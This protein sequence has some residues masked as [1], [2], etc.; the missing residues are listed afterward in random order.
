MTKVKRVNGLSEK[1]VIKMFEKQISAVSLDDGVSGVCYTNT[2]QTY[3]ANANNLREWS[4]QEFEK[5]IKLRNKRI[6][7]KKIITPSVENLFIELEHVVKNDFFKFIEI[8]QDLSFD[9]ETK[10]NVIIKKKVWKTFNGTRVGEHKYVSLG[11]FKVRVNPIEGRVQVAPGG[12]NISLGGTFHPHFDRGGDP[13]WGNV[14]GD[15]QTALLDFSLANALHYIASALTSYNTRNPYR[16]FEEFEIARFIKD[17]IDPTTQGY[18]PSEVVGFRKNPSIKDYAVIATLSENASLE[19]IKKIESE[20]ITIGQPLLEFKSQEDLDEIK[21]LDEE[22]YNKYAHAAR[23]ALEK[24]NR[25]DGICRHDFSYVGDVT[26]APL[27]AMTEAAEVFRGVAGEN[28]LIPE[29]FID[30]APMRLER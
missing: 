27:P 10:D 30:I 5:A 15:V 25:P 22:S 19:Y 11:I 9:L 3:M 7:L 17:G 8:Y 13:C 1:D 2:I 21:R 28:R 26:Q 6:K 18:N 16:S 20:Y 23:M 24:N 12:D 14:G 29:G 4:N